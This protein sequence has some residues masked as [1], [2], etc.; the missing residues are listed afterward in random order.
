M[1]K[2][3][4]VLKRDGST[5]EFSPAKIIRV[6]QAAGLKPEQARDLSEKITQWIKGLKQNSVSSLK[7]RD[8]VL[9][10]LR[11]VNEYAAGLFEWYEKSKTRRINQV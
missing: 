11:K 5:E 7:I 9:E 1:V 2:K 6:V 10:E 8:K 3:I 4:K